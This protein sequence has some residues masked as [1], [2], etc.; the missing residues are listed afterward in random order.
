MSKRGLA[1]MTPE[2]RRE[3]QSMGGRAVSPEQRTYSRD[4]KLASES[5]KKGGPRK[6]LMMARKRAAEQI[7]SQSKETEQ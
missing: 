7:S 6:A 3:I 4:K 1:A 5:G 2:K